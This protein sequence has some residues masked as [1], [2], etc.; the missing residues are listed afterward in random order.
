MDSVLHSVFRIPHF[1]LKYFFRLDSP[2]ALC[3]MRYAGSYLEWANFF[4]DDT[5]DY[6]ASHYVSGNV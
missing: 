1:C 6:D 3:P 5:K 2:Y 4:M